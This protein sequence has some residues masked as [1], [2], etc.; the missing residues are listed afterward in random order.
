MTTLCSLLLPNPSEN[1]ADDTGF[2]FLFVDLVS[3]LPLIL[4][5][6]Q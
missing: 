6:N 3:G 2:G 5:I 1:T 4:A